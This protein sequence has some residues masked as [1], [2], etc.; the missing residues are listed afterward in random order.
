MIDNETIWQPS[1]TSHFNIMIYLF[2]SVWWLKADIKTTSWIIQVIFIFTAQTQ[3]WSLTKQVHEPESSFRSQCS[4][5]SQL[6]PRVSEAEL[7]QYRPIL[8]VMNIPVIN[9][10]RGGPCGLCSRPNSAHST[11]FKKMDM[12]RQSRIN[13]LAELEKLERWHFPSYFLSFLRSS[14]K[15]RPWNLLIFH[16]RHF[17][18]LGNT[19]VETRSQNVEKREFLSTKIGTIHEGKHASRGHRVFVEYLAHPS[20]QFWHTSFI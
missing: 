20:F 9:A 2:A 4:V 7:T 12:H 6:L 13:N 18:A 5:Q 11:R 8:Q 10:R 17:V 1:L 14:P 3:V 19:R 15:M 16:R